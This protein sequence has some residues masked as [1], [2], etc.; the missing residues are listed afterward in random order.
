MYNTYLT[1]SRHLQVPRYYTIFTVVSFPWVQFFVS[2]SQQVQTLAIYLPCRC[3]C[4]NCT[5][6][7][8]RTVASVALATSEFLTLAIHYS[9]CIFTQGIYSPGTSGFTTCLIVHCLPRVT[10][11]FTKSSCPYRLWLVLAVTAVALQLNPHTD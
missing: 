2:L 3:E 8:H 6:M 10:L 1:H 11:A 9:S 7:E 5:D 4:R